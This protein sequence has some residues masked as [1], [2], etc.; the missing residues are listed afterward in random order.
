MFRIAVAIAL[1]LCAAPSTYAQTARDTWAQVTKTIVV[2]PGLDVSCWKDAGRSQI[3]EGPMTMTAVGDGTYEAIIG[4]QR[5]QKYNYLFFANAGF[6]APGGLMDFNEYYDVVP[7]SGF[8]RASTNGVTVNDTVSAY[9]G[10]VGLTFD[11]RRI[12]SVPTTIPPGDTLWVFN[13]FGETP[14]IVSSFSAFPEGETKIRLVWGDPYGFWG[15]NGEAFKAADVLAGGQF[16]IYRSLSESGPFRLIAALDGKENTFVDD[17]GTTGLAMAETYYYVIRCRDA[18][19]GTNLATDSFPTLSSDSSNVVH[20]TTSGPLIGFFVVQA[21]DWHV[22]ERTRGRVFLSPPEA[23][24][25]GRKYEARMVRVYLPPGDLRKNAFID[26]GSSNMEK[27][28]RG[29]E[30]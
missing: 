30:E 24:P 29:R 5:G 20:A 11:A 19:E 28:K 22:I 10:S 21:A 3:T 2:Q 1:F 6:P 8:I 17:S 14:G 7:T 16:L 23:P 25:W 27:R 26:S 12:L 4:L 18:Y 9:Y 15:Q 13:N